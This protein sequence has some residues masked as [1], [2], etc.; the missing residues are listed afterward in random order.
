MKKNILILILVGINII[1][2]LF[3]YAQKVRAEQSEADAIQQHTEV[4][5]MMEKVHEQEIRAEIEKIR[6]DSIADVVM[7]LQKKLDSLKQE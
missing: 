7:E 4:M 5:L 1:M 3:A 6:A 2:L